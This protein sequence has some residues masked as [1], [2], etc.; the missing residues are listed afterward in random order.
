MRDQV[1]QVT[2]KIYEL[3]GRIEIK[4]TRGKWVTM[5]ARRN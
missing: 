3:H 2:E 4:R 5:L 1:E